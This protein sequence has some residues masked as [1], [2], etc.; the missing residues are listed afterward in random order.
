MTLPELL[1]FALRGLTGHGLR[2][3]L[4]LL[5]VSIGIASVLVLT[6][7]GEGAKQYVVGQFQS[8]GTNLLIVLPGKTETSGFV[9]WGGVPNDLTLDDARA[10]DRFVPEARRVAPI[11]MGTEEVAYGALSRQIAV[12][13]ATP[14]YMKTRQLRMASGEFLPEDE[15]SRG[16]AVAVL[17]Q[18]AA[19]ELFRGE[20]PVGNVVRIGGWRMR[21][22]GV[23][24]GQGVKLGVN[25]DDIA[26]VPV[27]TGMRMF[28]RSSLFRILIQVHAHTDL[29]LAKQRVLELLTERHDEE[30]VTVI[31]QDAVANTFAG[32]LGMLTLFVTGIAAI[33][34]SVAGFG[35]MNVMLVSV[36][37][38]T[39]EIGLLKAVGVARRQILAAFVTE[40][41]IISGLGGLIGLA[42]G[43][44]LVHLGARLYPVFQASPPA[45]AIAAAMAVSLGVGI[46]FGMLPAWRATKLDP[47]LALGRR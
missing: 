36:S 9:G 1:R 7:L 21:V 14:A 42:M 39:R 40:A 31:T 27:A 16:A 23:L 10:I 22:I 30:D 38:R 18:K 17:G 12:I 6:A 37:E 3:A 46:V 28:N 33:S 2:T 41:A 5:G 20:D 34:L 15:F 19:R 43:F 47:V 13:G 4:S 25:F 11:S 32:I 45:W 26:I 24:A 8:L 44:A 35:I 29:D